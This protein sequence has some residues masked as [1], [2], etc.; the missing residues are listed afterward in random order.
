MYLKLDSSKLEEWMNESS[1]NQKIPTRGLWLSQRI[2][3]DHMVK[4]SMYI[5][6]EDPLN[7]VTYQNFKNTS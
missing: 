7:L 3:K 6:K 4:W 1:W 5:N 2:R